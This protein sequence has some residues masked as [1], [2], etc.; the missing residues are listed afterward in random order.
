MWCPLPKPPPPPRTVG[1]VQSSVGGVS[2]ALVPRPC[3]RGT[4][5]LEPPLLI[6]APTCRLLQRTPPP[7]PPHPTCVTARCQLVCYSQI[8]SAAATICGTNGC[9]MAFCSAQSP[10]VD[11][12][13]FLNG[14]MASVER[15]VGHGA[16]AGKAKNYGR[17]A[18]P[19]LEAHNSGREK[20][21]K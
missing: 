5:S 15:L 6:L 18:F 17:T 20:G 1:V 4:A 3:A 12:L 10:T 9:R 8:R 19:G 13:A 11:L 21:C 2:Q 16:E 14:H 7:P